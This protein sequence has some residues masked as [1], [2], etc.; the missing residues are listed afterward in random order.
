[1]AKLFHYVSNFD[2]PDAVLNNVSRTCGAV[3]VIYKIVILV[4]IMEYRPPVNT[5]S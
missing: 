4:S 1:M 2:T 5:G 3:I